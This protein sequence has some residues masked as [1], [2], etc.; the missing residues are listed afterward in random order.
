MS[1]EEK[2]K[3]E[4]SEEISVLK[5]Q[6]V[7]FKGFMKDYA[8]ISMAIAFI[9]GAASKDLVQSLVNNMI[10]PFINPL[11][12]TTN[13]WESYCR[14]FRWLFHKCTTWIFCTIY[15]KRSSA[16]YLSQNQFHFFDI[17]KLHNISTA[18]YNW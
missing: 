6:I 7:D 13:G 8:I 2:K 4:N 10:M 16:V 17:I 12:N 18:V 15:C 11:L 3:E 14:I 1:D 9:M 5:K